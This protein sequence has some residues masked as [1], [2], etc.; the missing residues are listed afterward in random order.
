MKH[1]LLAC[2]N[3]APCPL[4]VPAT[5]QYIENGYDHWV[6][7]VEGLEVGGTVSFL[8]CYPASGVYKSSGGKYNREDYLPGTNCIH[9]KDFGR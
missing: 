1:L 5:Y 3:R 6:T 7:S 2:A 8:R 9:F 4:I